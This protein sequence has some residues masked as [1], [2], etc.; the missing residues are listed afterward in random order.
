[1]SQVKPKCT[2][3]RGSLAWKPSEGPAVSRFPPD[4]KPR[5]V[6]QISQQHSNEYTNH[7]RAEGVWN[8][9]PTR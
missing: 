2:F 4:E 9:V 8:V 6:R 3:C 7:F 1:M 5:A